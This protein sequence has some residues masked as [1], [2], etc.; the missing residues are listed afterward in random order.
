[1]SRRFITPKESGYK[2]T[3]C[4]IHPDSSEYRVPSMIDEFFTEK[5]ITNTTGEVCIAHTHPLCVFL[6]Q[7]RIDRIKGA[8]LD[9][10]VQQLN[11]GALSQLS[12]MKLKLSD[13]EL[14]S[15]CRSRYCQTPSEVRAYLQSITT[16]EKTFHD[17][18]KR[19][20]DIINQQV[21]PKP[22]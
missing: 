11:A 1:M 9:T 17:E 15:M 20:L 6:N 5:G 21:E 3:P 2:V 13:D 16:S 4:S 12:E 18:V 14:V 22:E 8:T 19:H 10:Y 7:K